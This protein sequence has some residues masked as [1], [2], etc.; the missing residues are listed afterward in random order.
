M[1]LGSRRLEAFL[2]EAAQ[3]IELFQYSRSTL[4]IKKPVEVD[5]LVK[6]YP[7]VPLSCRSDLA[8]RYLRH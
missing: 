6:A 7:M 3:N 5:V 8:R 1:C 2:Y 4:K